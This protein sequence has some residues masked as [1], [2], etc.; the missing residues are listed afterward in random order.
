MA[1]SHTKLHRHRRNKGGLSPQLKV[2]ILK[3]VS[4]E[5]LTIADRLREHGFVPVDES[6]GPLTGVCST[7]AVHRIALTVT[8]AIATAAPIIIRAPR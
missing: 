2:P 8:I 1:K 4:S 3:K 7:A 5:L 6:C